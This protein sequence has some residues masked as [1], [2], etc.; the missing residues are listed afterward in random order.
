[1]AT[2]HRQV[3]TAHWNISEQAFSRSRTLHHPP[4]VHLP[5]MKVPRKEFDLGS[6]G[7]LAGPIAASGYEPA[8][9]SLGPDPA[10]ARPSSAGGGAVRLNQGA[11]THHLRGEKSIG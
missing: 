10:L 6:L 9:T 7:C 8:S 5:S 11:A 1:M 4:T 2:L 3:F